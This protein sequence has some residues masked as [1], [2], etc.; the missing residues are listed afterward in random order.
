MAKAAAK[1]EVQTIPEEQ[2]N[3]LM[4]LQRGM[5]QGTSVE[6]MERLMTLA[7]RYEAT[8]ARKAYDKAMAELRQDL[9]KIV[10]DREVSF[11]PGRAAYKYEDL[12]S[13]TEALSPVMAKHGLSFRWRTK[14]TD[15]GG[16]LVTCIIAHE[17]GHSEETSLEARPDTSGNKNPLQAIGS[18]TSYLQRY[19]LKAGVG[20]AAAADDDAQ[21][22]GPTTT[23]PNNYPPLDKPTAPPLDNDDVPF[24][25]Q[26]AKEDK[27]ANLGVEPGNNPA[28]QA[29]A[30][31]E[32]PKK[33]PTTYPQTTVH[34]ELKKAIAAYVANNNIG[35]MTKEEA[36]RY[37]LKHCSIREAVFDQKTKKQIKPAH[38]GHDTLERLSEEHAKYA[39]EQFNKIIAQ[40][41]GAK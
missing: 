18:A 39:L 25:W 30:A 11:G 27:P 13:V 16:I 9:P 31:K 41:G 19:T 32:S 29:I 5:E 22:A 33:G 26:K 36:E 24:S 6:V 20:V 40:A 37:I 4:L 12:S 28:L 38:P 34:E 1:K 2:T 23:R 3:P 10:K 17:G 35:K 14:S 7:E 15:N 21:S 8:V